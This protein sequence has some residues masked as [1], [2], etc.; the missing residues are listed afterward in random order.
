MPQRLPCLALFLGAIFSSSAPFQAKA[1]DFESLQRQ[2]AERIQPLLKSKCLECHSTDK[3]EGD[4]DLEQFTTVAEIRSSAEAW[5]KVIEMIDNREMPPKDA[6]Q[7]SPTEHKELGAWLD[8][9]IAA[10]AA[11]TAGDPGP[12]LLRRLNN[13]EYTYTI[14]QLTG[15]PLEP[16]RE[17]PA[18]SASGEGFTNTGNSLVMSP[19]LLSKYMDAAKA[20]AE[21]AILL[22]D[23]IRY[24]IYTTRRDWTDDV[25]KRLRDFYAKYTDPNG[26]TRVDLQGLQW[27]TNAGGRLPVGTYLSALIKER[28]RLTRGETT[29]AQVAK[30]N[31]L[32]AKYMGIL[33]DVLKQPQATALL[34]RIHE[35]FMTAK[36]EDVPALVAEIAAWQQA[37]TRFQSVGHMKPWLAAVEP[38][39]EQQE[40]RIKLE[41]AEPNA[42]RVVLLAAGDAGDG[43]KEDHVVWQRPRLVAPGRT[44]IMVRDVH[45]VQQA[46]AFQRKALLAATNKCLAAAADYLASSEPPAIPKLAEQHGVDGA[47]LNVWFDYLSIAPSGAV[48]LDQLYTNQLRKTAGYDFVNGW[49]S[50]ETPNIMASAGDTHVR[51]PGNMKPHGVVVHPS[52]TLNAVVSWR[53][54]MTGALRVE[55][56]VTHAH[57]ECGNGV[58]WAIELRRGASRQRL[59][60]GIAHG[61]QAVVPVPVENVRVRE[62]ELISL[63]IGP[64]DANHACDLTDIEFKLTEQQANEKPRQWNLTADV[65]PNILAGNPHADQF[66]NS[67]VWSFYSEP[68]QAGDLNRAVL[69]AGSLLHQWISTEERQPRTELANQVRALLLAERPDA[70]GPNRVLWDQTHDVNGPLLGPLLDRLALQ[71][72]NDPLS[73]RAGE[74]ATELVVGS[75]FG[76]PVVP[77]ASIDEASLGATAPAVIRLNLPGE[78]SHGRQFVVTGSLD[79]TVGREGSV[80]LQATLSPDPKT[81]ASALAL[82]AALPL[83]TQSNSASRKRFAEATYAFREKFPAA[84][85][86]TKIVPVDE[87]V[88]LALFQREDDNLQRLMLEADEVAQLN[89]LWEELHF[90]SQDLLTVE[91]A[92]EQLMQ[93]ATQ[94]S[95]P[96]LFEH[97]REPIK[98]RANAFRAALV[99]A[100]PQHL[101]AVTELAGRAFRRPLADAERTGLTTL[102]QRLRE[103]GLNHESA[104]RLLIVRVLVSTSFLYRLEQSQPGDSSSPISDWEMATRLSYFLWSGPPDQTLLDAASAGQL[105]DGDAI[106]QQTKRMLRESRVERLAKQFAC[107]W[108]HIQDIAELDEKS[109]RH[110]PEFAGIRGALQKEA[111]LFFT[112]LVQNDGSVL[113]IFDADYTFLNESLARHY[114]IDG[115][116]GEEWRRVGGVRKSKRGG[117][118]TF[119]ATLAKQSGASRTSPIL[120]GNWISEVLL[121]ERLPRP[122]K[123]VPVLPADES[124]ETLTVRQLVERHTEDERCASC[125]VRI[126]PFGFALE[127][128]DA[129]GRW[130]TKDLAGHALDTAVKLPDGTQIADIDQLRDYLV[131]KKRDVLLKQ[132][133][134][135]LLGYALG[136][137]I[138][139]SDQQLLAEMQ[140]QLEANDFRISAAL[141]A[142]VRSRQFTHIRDQ[143]VADLASDP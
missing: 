118:L 45:D 19:A 55:A 79:G 84:L 109:E 8:D 37:L 114:G 87:V 134:R 31:G 115:V 116:T 85:C 24:S 68:I 72:R 139:L 97:L 131:H 23:G 122:P 83:F 6:Q 104:V 35:R 25:L 42:L 32:N 73:T 140:S 74:Q 111:E 105:H 14:Q 82:T 126:D 92:Y 7:L 106:A 124:S 36:P 41:P 64:R 113:N 51:I 39:V 136:R 86:Y 11:A 78:L 10:E 52:P 30:Q 76:Q 100:E 18:D 128:F 15:Q 27:E 50:A 141:E 137:S 121:G 66:G 17:F 81:P 63:L 129:I 28:E 98:E 61:G 112:D 127:N 69:P 3:R 108:L 88:T 67:E 21:H 101:K 135:K 56:I 143:D 4:L 70:D 142:I 60:A 40:L 26:S 120:R 119:G 33:W 103:E 132:F 96:K 2:Y 75:Q 62:G 9:F 65:S 89:R 133:C 94:D 117:V 71:A 20:V 91:D 38:F 22:P 57:P 13:A 125:H 58:A 99:A 107:Q 77:G 44:D 47:L 95:D 93:F 16:A 29:A 123:D 102:Y 90:V 54:P 110:F 138:R 1:A 46:F 48:R 49:G 80:Q 34:N 12:V 130:R 43:S 59:A 53:S 5:L